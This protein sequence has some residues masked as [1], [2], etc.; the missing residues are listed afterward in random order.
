MRVRVWLAAGKV[1]SLHQQGTGLIRHELAPGPHRGPWSC[2]CKDAGLSLAVI[3]H[4]HG[5]LAAAGPWCD[6]EE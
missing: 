3:R 5:L 1:P 2:L 4:A 6:Q